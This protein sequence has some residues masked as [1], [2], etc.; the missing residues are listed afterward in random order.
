LDALLH[1]GL[2]VFA[3][4]PDTLDQQTL[5]LTNGLPLGL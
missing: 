4:L 2:E 3:H 1:L 5:E